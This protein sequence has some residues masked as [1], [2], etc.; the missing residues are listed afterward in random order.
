LAKDVAKAG[1]LDVVIRN[2]NDGSTFNG[3]IDVADDGQAAD[4]SAR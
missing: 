4:I 2:P 3:V 1:K